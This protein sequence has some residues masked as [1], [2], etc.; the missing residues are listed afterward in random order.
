MLE[1]YLL[2]LA[3]SLNTRHVLNSWMINSSASMHFGQLV[4]AV[5]LP[6]KCDHRAIFVLESAAICNRLKRFYSGLTLASLH[7]AECPTRN[8]RSNEPI[9]EIVPEV[10]IH[11]ATTWTLPV[12][13]FLYAR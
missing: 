4:S 8:R 5:A 6:A 10:K 12:E 13:R 3:F 11:C 7:V 1:E 2:C 9:T